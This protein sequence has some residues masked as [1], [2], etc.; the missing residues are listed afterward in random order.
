VNPG[1]PLIV[2]GE[3]VETGMGEVVNLNHVRKE[4]TAKE[5]KA[6]AAEN[7]AAHGRTK[8]E[9]TRSEAEKAH[10]VA[11]LDAHRREKGED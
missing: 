4:R 7:R 10:E 11:R 6:K 8:A 5:K 2:P 9:R 3:D 1:G